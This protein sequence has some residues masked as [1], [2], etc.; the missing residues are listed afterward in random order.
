MATETTIHF[1]VN[2]TAHTVTTDPKRSLL[3]VL[4]E[5]LQ[6]TGTKYGC[7]EGQCRACTVLIDGESA[8]SCLTDVGDV[9]KREVL[10]IEGLAHGD[11]LDPIQ[12]AMMEEGAFQCGYCTAGMI[13]GLAGVLK[14]NP[15]ASEA[16]VMKE[17]QHHLCR[18]CSYVKY[19]SAIRRVLSP[20]R[21][22]LK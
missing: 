18:C 4:R 10:T 5:D 2:G 21:K 13:M 9:D 3:E 6:L 17:M 7:G 14:K 15:R 16:E 19:R 20:N 22:D 12:E 1:S 11:K 8:N